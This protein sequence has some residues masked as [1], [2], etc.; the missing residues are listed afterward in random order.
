[1]H[2]RARS[3]VRARR[4]A[5]KLDVEILEDR[6]PVSEN[7]GTLLAVSA[8]AGW[9]DTLL[10]SPRTRE[11][12]DR[13]IEATESSNL[14]AP[15]GLT[16]TENLPVAGARSSPVETGSQPVAAFDSIFASVA[17]DFDAD[18]EQQPF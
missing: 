6:L 2:R 8:L 7:F 9:A 18:A 1:M 5:R 15:N 12:A 11:L 13:R 14:V 10:E 4:G 3:A 16:L 17:S